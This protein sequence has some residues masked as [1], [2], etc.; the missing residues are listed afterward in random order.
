[1]NHSTVNATEFGTCAAATPNY[2]R[3]RVNDPHTCYHYK[4]QKAQP[5]RNAYSKRLTPEFKRKPAQR[6]RLP[7]PLLRSVAKLPLDIR[8]FHSA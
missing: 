1:M 7:S 8:I 2:R 4:V 5:K 3:R 6:R